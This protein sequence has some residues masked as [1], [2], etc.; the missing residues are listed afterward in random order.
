MSPAAIMKSW[1]VAAKAS[2]KAAENTSVRPKRE[3]MSGFCSDAERE[4]QRRR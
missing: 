1:L 4:D 2:A 3:R